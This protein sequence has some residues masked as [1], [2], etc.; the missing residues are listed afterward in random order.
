MTEHHTTRRAILVSTATTALSATAI[1]QPFATSPAAATSAETTGDSIIEEI[2]GKLKAALDRHSQAFDIFGVA[3]NAMFEWERRNPKPVLPEIKQA[4]DRAVDDWI[5]ASLEADDPALFCAANP[6]PNAHFQA[7]IDELGAALTNRSKR[8]AV[9]EAQCGYRAA[10]A[11]KTAASADVASI[12]EDLANTPARSLPALA[13]KARL[14]ERLSSA[15]LA[16]S[17]VDDLQATEAD[18]ART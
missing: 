8:K 9:A 4:S 7:A 1:A 16:W 3:E 18:H 2:A 13:I 12:E 17:L 11:E 10:E 14:A 15:D 5:R 6:S